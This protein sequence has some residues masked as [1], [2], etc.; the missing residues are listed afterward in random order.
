MIC[1]RRVSGNGKGF[2]QLQKESVRELK[3][4]PKRQWG[5]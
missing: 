3:I 2:V 5:R 4:N 1:R